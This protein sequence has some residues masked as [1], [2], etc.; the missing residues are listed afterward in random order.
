MFQASVFGIPV[1]ER[2]CD[3][4]MP[5]THVCAFGAS[6]VRAMALELSPWLPVVASFVA[7][8]ISVMQDAIRIRIARGGNKYEFTGGFN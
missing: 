2:R 7:V 6:C 3:L 5:R 1:A 8:S 4:A